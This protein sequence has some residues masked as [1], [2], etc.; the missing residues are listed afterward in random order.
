MITD[1]ENKVI[2]EGEAAQKEY[3]KFSEWCEDGSKNLAY[4]IKTAK[5][6][7]EELKA[8]IEEE[9]STAES[10]TAEIEELAASISSD[11][12]DL[13]ATTKIRSKELADF[14]AEEKEMV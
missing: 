5:A 14:T 10:L 9:K 4:E 7:I 13:E 11:Q 8:T 2:A 3:E 12:A 1:L 6:Q